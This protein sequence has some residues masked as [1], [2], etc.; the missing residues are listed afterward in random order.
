MKSTLYHVF[1]SKEITETQDIDFNIIKTLDSLQDAVFLSHCIAL[2]YMPT[3]TIHEI[4]SNG[5]Q[6]QTII[7]VREYRTLHNNVETITRIGVL[8]TGGEKHGSMDK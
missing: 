5:K 6:G 7:L 8:K 4:S 1:I 3:G 2:T